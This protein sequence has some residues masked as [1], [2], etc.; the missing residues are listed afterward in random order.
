[1]DLHWHFCLG[2]GVPSI[3]LRRPDDYYERKKQQHWFIFFLPF[4]LA[5][6]CFQSWTDLAPFMMWLLMMMVL[7]SKLELMAGINLFWTRRF[8]LVLCSTSMS[9][10]MQYAVVEVRGCK[11]LLMRRRLAS[12]SIKARCKWLGKVIALTKPIPN[13]QDVYNCVVGGL[14]FWLDWERNPVPQH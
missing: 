10:I 3:L 11:E 12:S 8:V 6:E 5:I 7:L 14:L 9:R 4:W 1:M 2:L 13:G